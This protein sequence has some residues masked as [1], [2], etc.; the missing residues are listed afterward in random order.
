M[1]TSNKLILAFLTLILGVVLI[2]TIASQSLAVTAKDIALN[3]S[4]TLAVTTCLQYNVLTGW[5]VNETLSGCNITVTNYPKDWEIVDCP[6]DELVVYN[7]TYTAG[8]LTE[9][10]D[11]VF[12]EGA[13]VIQMQNT[14]STQNG[15]VNHTYLDYQH[16]PSDYMNLGWGRTLTN[17]ISGFFALTLLAV[18]VG[19][20]YSVAKDYDII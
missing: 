20:F 3:E 18:S 2:G 5:T 7:N 9:G 11:Y 8:T 1:E 6:I 14:T 17:M 16:C 12:F 19:L 13:G 15:T 10:T 4:H